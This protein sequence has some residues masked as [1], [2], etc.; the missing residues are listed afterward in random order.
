[1]TPELAAKT[2]DVLLADQGG[3][4][5]TAAIDEA[6]V[7][8]VLEL[9]SEYGQPRKEPTDPSRYYDLTYGQRAVL[10]LSIIVGPVSAL[11]AR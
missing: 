4:D 2:Y 5:R 10:A 11:A 3:F 6:G 1:M 8:T 9:R 7:P